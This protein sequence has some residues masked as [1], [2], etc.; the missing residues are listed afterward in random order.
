MVSTVAHSLDTIAHPPAVAKR[1]KITFVIV[2]TLSFIALLALFI[3]CKKEEEEE[4]YMLFQSYVLLYDQA[5][6][7]TDV[8]AFFSKNNE[9]GFRLPDLP[10]G[11]SIYFNGIAPS[12]N[13]STY[14]RYE[15]SFPGR[16][17]GTFLL[18]RPTGEFSNPLSLAD[19][20]EIIVDTLLDT[21]P[22]AAQFTIPFLGGA[23]FSRETV[24]IYISQGSSQ[25]AECSATQAG[26]STITIPSTP[27]CSAPDSRPAQRPSSRHM[28]SNSQ[29]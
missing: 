23:L 25:S 4:P 12:N 24:T 6:D 11:S 8:Y 17:N 21:I 10:D 5:A 9:S 14:R 19:S 15:W 20:R 26:D 27:P 18:H 3:S 13:N 22:L 29:A 7:E 1:R 2:R 16:T 28:R